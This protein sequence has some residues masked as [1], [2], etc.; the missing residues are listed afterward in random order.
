MNPV[1]RVLAFLAVAALVA[2][3]AFA[4][5]YLLTPHPGT[6]TEPAAPIPAP[7]VHPQPPAPVKL[8]EWNTYHGNN[9]LTG[10]ADASFP[11]TLEVLWRIKA[12]APVR[13]T[14]VV[15][16]GHIFYATARGDVVATDLTGKQVWAKEFFTGEKVKDEP[17]R[18]RI[19]APLACFDKLVLFGTSEGHFI[20]LDSATGEERWRVQLIG[21]IRGTANYLAGNPNR[22]Y[23]I[24]QPTGVLHCIDPQ[25]GAVLWKGEGPER[26]DGS[27]SVSPD[28]IVF[29]SC[30]AAIHVFDPVTGKLLRNIKIDGDSQVAG[31]VA[32][33]KG[34]VFSGCRSG[35]VLQV[36]VKE[37]KILW[38]NEQSESEVYTTPAVNDTWVVAASDDGNIYGMDRVD[39]KG[40]WAFDTKGSPT[41]AV[42]AGDK[43]V[44]A[45][46]G[47]LFLLRLADGAK[48]WSLKISDEI[49]APAVTG[50]MILVGSEDGSV[51]ALGAPKTKESGTS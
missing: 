36:D 28:A 41:S 9:A 50:G 11:D 20:A 12:G 22:I 26:C 4:L 47:E 35:K 14:P 49:S 29:G 46:D 18:E 19:D 48:A 3:G 45:A 32:Q 25:T 37:G 44:V 10:V 8:A 24:E 30:A 23:I 39:G 42:I 17:V 1:S 7:Q 27:P 21:P 15:H 2:F 34:L 43:V 51:V 5:V 38:A 33:D 31:G 16:D 13:E 40:K 6:K